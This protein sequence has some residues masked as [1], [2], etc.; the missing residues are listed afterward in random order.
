M[1]ITQK[2]NAIQNFYIISGVIGQSNNSLLVVVLWLQVVVGKL[3]VP[4]S[5]QILELGPDCEYPQLHDKKAS[6]STGNPPLTDN[7]L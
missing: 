7:L 3:Q 1:L 5:R 6:V 4:E 2:W